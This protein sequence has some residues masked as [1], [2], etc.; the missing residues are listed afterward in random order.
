[1]AEISDQAGLAQLVAIGVGAV[2]CG[3]FFGWQA[4]LAGGFWNGCI[5][6]CLVTSFYAGLCLSIGEV[7]AAIPNARSPAH[8]AEHCLGSRWALAVAVAETIKLILVVGVIIVGVGSYLCEILQ[9]PNVYNP[10]VWMAA[11]A[12]DA[13]A[14]SFGGALSLN[15][16]SAMTMVSVLILTIFYIGA[17]AQSPML[18]TATHG[19]ADA[20][21]SNTVSTSGVC[22]AW[23]F[24][25][26][27]FLGCEELP[28]AKRIARSPA[29]LTP[30]LQRTFLCLVAISFLTFFL[31]AMIAPGGAAVL[32]TQPFP[33]LVG[34][35]AVF[36]DS[37]STRY[38]CLTLTVGLWAGLHSFTFAAGE[39]VSQC[40]EAG[41]LPKALAASKRS[42]VPLI[43]IWSAAIFSFLAVLLLHYAIGD[44]AILGSVLISAVLAASLFSYLC[45]L[46][47]FFVLRQWNE[48]PERPED[49]SKLGTF[50]A[51]IATVLGLAS[52]GS[53]AYLCTMRP[54]YA[55]GIALVVGGALLWLAVY[56]RYAARAATTPHAPGGHSPHS[57]QR[58]NIVTGAGVTRTRGNTQTPSQKL[59]S[60]QSHVSPNDT[61]QQHG[62]L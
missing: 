62:S 16:Q 59:I 29:L 43:A 48:L 36:G 53:I 6:L 25:M 7:A 24:C 2:I 22:F 37:T 28:L 50:G 46:A 23:P 18:S 17:L 3:D 13:T 20:P 41:Y 56:Y 33:L 47:C 38:A 45:Q 11:M 61:S 4:S 12:L 1:M 57:S 40:A 58:S 9:Y 14:L 51:V 10:L 19:S 34:Y 15:F 21:F 54:S 26:W 27:F 55:Y 5:A 8:F 30:A 44:S 42:G 31:S 32:S 49:V 39:M 35:R 52:L 60:S